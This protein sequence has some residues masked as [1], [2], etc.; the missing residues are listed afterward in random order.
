MPQ[1]PSQLRF[2]FRLLLSKLEIFSI[3][4]TRMNAHN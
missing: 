2:R 4:H 3:V 1:D